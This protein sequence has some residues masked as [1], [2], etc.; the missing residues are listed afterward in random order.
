MNFDLQGLLKTSP[1]FTNID[2]SKVNTIDKAL[3]E[4]YYRLLTTEQLVGMSDAIKQDIQFTGKPAF[5]HIE[6]NEWVCFAS[7]EWGE[8]RPIKR[9][10]DMR[11]K[12]IFE[13][14]FGIKVTP[15]PLP[16]PPIDERKY[17]EWALEVWDSS[18]PFSK[19][20]EFTYDQARSYHGFYTESEEEFELGVNHIMHILKE[21]KGYTWHDPY[22]PPKEKNLYAW[23]E[24]ESDEASFEYTIRLNMYTYDTEGFKKD[25]YVF[26]LMFWEELHFAVESKM[27]GYEES[28]GISL[29]EFLEGRAGRHRVGKVR[30]CK[31][32]L[33]PMGLF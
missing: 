25:L 15:D 14:A 5:H 31:V 7:I 27:N 22:L 18:T 8:R 26:E 17:E 33:D 11:Y 30:G 13:R 1:L 28:C 29:F 23:M 20:T 16:L 21:T 19:A 3:N 4:E 9:Y 2:M 10:F 6:D 12:H 32:I 24:V